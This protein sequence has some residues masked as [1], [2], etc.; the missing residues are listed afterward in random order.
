MAMEMNR[1][2]DVVQHYRTMLRTEHVVAEQNPFHLVTEP[3]DPIA[4]R[5]VLSVCDRLLAM[6]RD[7]PDRREKIMRWYG[8]LQG[9]MWMLGYFTVDQL[10]DH[11][12]PDAPAPGEAP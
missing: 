9:A 7:E 10:K 5:H 3:R 4:K 11:S 1:I 2:A 6:V 8:F 12:R